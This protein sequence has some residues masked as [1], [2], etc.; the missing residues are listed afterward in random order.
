[1]TS[2]KKRPEQSSKWSCGINTFMTGSRLCVCDPESCD[3][4]CVAV[5]IDPDCPRFQCWTLPLPL[6]VHLQF[7]KINPGLRWWKWLFTAV[8]I[9][10][11]W[12]CGW[13]RFSFFY[14]EFFHFVL[15]V[16]LLITWFCLAIVRIWDGGSDCEMAVK[17]L[18]LWANPENLLIQ[19][20]FL[21]AILP[22]HTYCSLDFS[23]CEDLRWW[24][25]LQN[26]CENLVPVG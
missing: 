1:M 26:S 4:D 3:D 2:G 13:S 21:S 7:T 9:W 17:I 12:I 6:I 16:H 18:F 5:V 10:L 20:S 14:P 15:I 24:K 22:S 23:D 8:K 19:I 11:F 25:W